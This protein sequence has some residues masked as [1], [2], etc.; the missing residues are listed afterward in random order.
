MTYALAKKHEKELNFFSVNKYITFL[1]FFNLQYL[2]LQFY[3]SISVWA[4]LLP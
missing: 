1:F 3:L 4:F 2:N